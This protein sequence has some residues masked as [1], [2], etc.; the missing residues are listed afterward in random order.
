[1]KRLCL[2]VSLLSAFTSTCAAAPCVASSLAAYEELGELGCTVGLFTLKNFNFDV[3]STTGEVVPLN[4]GEIDVTPGGSSAELALRFS[5]DGFRVSGFEG[6]VYELAYIVDPP[7]IIFRFMDE[8]LTETPVFPGRVDI[9]TTVCSTI[10]V[11][12]PPGT[13]SRLNVFHAGTSSN[14][15]D[16][17]LFPLANYLDIRHEISLQANGASADFT[18]LGNRAGVVPEPG[19]YGMAAVALLIIAVASR[20]RVR[21]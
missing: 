17:V 6:V 14:L 1:M 12:C 2:A 5:S 21:G 7:P 9:Q 10:G 3:L 15:S 16:Q 13:I 19:T 11:I 18:G 20:S 8:L 4:A